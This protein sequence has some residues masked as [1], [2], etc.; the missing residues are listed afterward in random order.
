MMEQLVYT[1]GRYR[2]A[3]VPISFWAKTFPSVTFYTKF[4]RHVFQGSVK[5]KRSQYGGQ[6]WSQNSLQVLR[7]LESVGITI[8][9]RGID[10]LTRLEGPCVFIANH[11]S[12]LETVVLPAII[13]P[14]KHITFVVKQNLLQYPL[15]KDILHA[16]DPIAVSRKHPRD[17]FKA[18]MHGGIARLKA[19]ISIVVF[20]QTTRTTIVD[21]AQFNTLGIKL[22]RKAHV[23]VIPIALVTD[24][25]GKGR[26]L[27]DFGKI[28]PAKRVLIA[29][30]APLWIQHDGAQEHTKIL[31]FITTTVKS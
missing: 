11:M 27:N 31:D 30:G 10:H 26:Y 21:P 13:Q 15:F 12:T 2:T 24:A 17:D 18:V 20:P 23:P 29:F 7:A 19:G 25:W 3:S 5:A 9:I 8:E 16:R 28:D 1:H 14:I 22:A 6:A 4:L